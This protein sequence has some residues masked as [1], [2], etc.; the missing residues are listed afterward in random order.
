[1]VML[2]L[3]ALCGVAIGRTRGGRLASL[4]AL[5]FHAP[6]LLALAALAQAGFGVV[7]PSYRSVAIALAYAVVGIWLVLNACLQRGGI[8]LGCVVLGGG[9]L[10]NLIAIM[11]NGGMPVSTEALERVGAPRS[12]SVTEGHF[13]KHVAADRDT[14]MSGLGDV[15]PLP[16]AATVVSIGDIVMLTGIALVVGS[17]MTGAGLRTGT[18]HASSANIRADR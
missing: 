14:R 6:L 17:G 10:L 18:E 16:F 12:M 5:R 9:L 11:P 8:R 4:S 7:T 15:I 2:C 13:Y 3:G 1:M